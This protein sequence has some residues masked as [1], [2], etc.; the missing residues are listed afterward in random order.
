MLEVL[1]VNDE[2]GPS[3]RLRGSAGR[4]YRPASASDGDRP[5]GRQGRGPGDRSDREQPDRADGGD[6]A[7]WTVTGGRAG[8]HLRLVLGRRRAP[9]GRGAGAPGA[10]AGGEGVRLSAGE[11]RCPRRPG[12]G[13]PT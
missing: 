10:P 12:S 4:G 1:H 6:R 3:G 13:R 9:G 5:N 11:E 2:G 8:G 7:S